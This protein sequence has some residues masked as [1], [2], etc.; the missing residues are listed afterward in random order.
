[1]SGL[2][3]QVTEQIIRDHFAPFGHVLAVKLPINH[4]TGRQRDLALITMDSAESVDRAIA[5]A[6]HIIMGKRVK[7]ICVGVRGKCEK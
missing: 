6:S 4:E 7:E 2:V 3:P 1:M 5:Q